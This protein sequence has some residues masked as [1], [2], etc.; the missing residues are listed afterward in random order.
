[1]NIDKSRH[2]K[3]FK[4]IRFGLFAFAYDKKTF[5]RIPSLD[6]ARAV[7]FATAL[8]VTVRFA[9]PGH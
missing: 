3:T 6:G 9:F 5:S 4:V 8:F 2:M 1:M 7:T